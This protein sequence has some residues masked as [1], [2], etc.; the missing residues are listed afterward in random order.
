MSYFIICLIF[1]V[2]MAVFSDILQLLIKP[3][4]N[5]TLH[6]VKICRSSL[7]SSCCSIAKWCI[8]LCDPLGY[9]MPGSLVF[10]YLPEFAQIHVH[11][12]SNHI[13]LCHLLFLEPSIFP[14]IRVFSSESTLSIKWPKLWNFSF[15]ISPSDV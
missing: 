11:W 1:L 13:K 8:T 9:S 7:S 10:Y 6:I 3:H 5:T 12:V 4:I 14:S 2:L 15:S